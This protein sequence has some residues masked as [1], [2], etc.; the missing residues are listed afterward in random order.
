MNEPVPTWVPLLRLIHWASAAL[1]ISA[2]SLG[3]YM[4]QLVDDSAYRFDLTQTHKSI[5]ITV[6]VLTVARLWLRTLTTAPGAAPAP[7][8]LFLAAKATHLGLYGLLLFLPLSGWLMA[9]TSPLRLPTHIF[10]VFALPYPLA[11]DLMTYR[12][13]HAVHVMAAVLL[14]TLIL[15][16]IS[17]AMFHG[18]S[19]R[20]SPTGRGRLQ[21]VRPGAR[22]GAR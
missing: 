21:G 9:T 14:A 5:G 12:I 19:G 4:V 1:I 16:H 11:P 10:G 22:Q 15:L 8:W 13:T 2:L 17:A 18:L 6:I 3:I 7:A 20:W